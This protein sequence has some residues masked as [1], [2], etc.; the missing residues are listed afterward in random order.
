MPGKIINLGGGVV[1]F[2]G[3]IDVPMPEILQL[4]DSL[5]QDSL[6][7]Q[8]EYILDESGKQ[9]HA[10]NK[11]GFI[12]ELDEISKNPIRIQEL[13][14]PFFRK[15]EETIY[16]CLLEYIEMFPSALQCL[17][18]KSE[19]HVLKY[20]TGAKLGFHCD[21]DVNYRYGQ[22]PPFEH[23]TRNVISVL[24]Y[25]NSNCDDGDCGE[26]SFTGGA[27]DIPYFGITIKPR[28]GTIL[29]MPANYLGAHEIHEVTSGSRYSYLS[30]FAQGS[31]NQER[32]I[33][34]Q[35]PGG[36]DYRPVGGQWWLPTIVE[37]YERYLMAKYGDEGKIPMGA[38]PFKSRK[39]DHK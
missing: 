26:H 29:F 18:W 23:A 32:G 15:C 12:Y 24:V 3:V 36:T 2:D 39:D 17:W 25:L 14:H 9:T 34:P 37:D 21:N 22:M 31:P 20:P 5:S 33:S 10:V 6:N 16:Q 19:G 27:M 11:S 1:R 7:E 30:W 8:Y 38:T 4:I 35:E 13:K 28:M